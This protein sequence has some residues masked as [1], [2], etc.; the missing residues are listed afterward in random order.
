ML[1]RSFF[2]DGNPRNCIDTAHRKRF[3]F[4]GRLTLGGDGLLRIF[5]GFIVFPH[6]VKQLGQILIARCP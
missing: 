6:F 4:V 5:D 3:V 2:G 1:N